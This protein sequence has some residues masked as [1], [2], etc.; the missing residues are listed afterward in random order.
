MTDLIAREREVVLGTY[1]RWP[2]VISRAVG[3]YVWDE[4]G[5]RYLD[6]GAGIGVL[7]LG[8]G[9]PAVLRAIQR[10]A[11]R[12]M[13]VS[14]LYYTEPMI[15]LAGRLT[16]RTGLSKVFFTNSGT[17]AIEAALKFSRRTVG[18]NGRRTGFVACE[19]G[20][21]GRSFGSLS[22]THKAAFRA[23]FEPLLPGVR[24]GKLNDLASFAALIDDTVAAVIVE[25]VQGEGGIHAADPAFLAGLRRLCDERGALL[26]FDEIQCG[27]GR[28]GHLWA[29]TAAD[30]LPDILTLAKPLGGGLPLGAAVVSERVAAAMVPGDH[31][32]TFGANPVACAAGLAVLDLVDDGEFLAQV[33]ERGEALAAGVRRLAEMH[34]RVVTGVRHVGLMVGIDVAPKSAQVVEK[35]LARGLI[36]LAAG[37]GTLRLLPPLNIE[38]SQVEEALRVMD[39]VFRELAAV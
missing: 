18:G 14:N 28:T 39:E 21:H 6:F 38:A 16:S 8:H 22:I 1:K 32:T 36:L 26:V 12:V 24:F 3:P 19:K 15:A 9:H 37:E 23:P 10:Q 4:A 13:H 25:P 33:R 7:A 30:V 34:P 11:E 27:V 5:R 17:E 20:F 29:H 31:G 35:A 2:L